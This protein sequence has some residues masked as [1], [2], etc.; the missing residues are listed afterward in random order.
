METSNPADK[1]AEKKQTPAPKPKEATK[2]PHPWD[3][4]ASLHSNG[5]TTIYNFDK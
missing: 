2:A 5:T 3:K 1:P 4:F